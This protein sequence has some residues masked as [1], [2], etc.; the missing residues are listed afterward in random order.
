MKEFSTGETFHWG[1]KFLGVN[2]S[3]DILREG[4]YP[5]LVF[6][7][8]LLLL[9]LLLDFACEEVPE[10]IF[11]RFGI[12]WWIFQSK[13]SPRSISRKKFSI[14]GGVSEKKFYERGISFR[15]KKRP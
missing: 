1:E 7:L 11:S 14:G 3:W 2:I 4:N 13:N 15:I 8:L 9:L 10:E 12:V 6:F 5:D